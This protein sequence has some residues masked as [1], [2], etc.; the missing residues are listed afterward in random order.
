MTSAISHLATSPIETAVAS[1]RIYIKVGALNSIA[2][3]KR[4]EDTDLFPN[5]QFL[6][7]MG[8]E[9]IGER[10]GSF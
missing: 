4:V 1:F 8:V 10:D 7:Q 3:R 5:G 2:V 9:D 6:L